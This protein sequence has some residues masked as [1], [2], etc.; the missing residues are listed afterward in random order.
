MNNL[1]HSTIHLI[2]VLCTVAARTLHKHNI[3]IKPC[4]SSVAQLVERHTDDLATLVRVL[5]EAKL[6]VSLYAY[7]LLLGSQVLSDIY[8]VVYY[9]CSRVQLV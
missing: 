5:V 4:I 9:H 3:A 8:S 6:V 7:L 1:V 2:Y